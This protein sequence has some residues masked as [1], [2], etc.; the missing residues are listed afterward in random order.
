[1]LL[2]T[3]LLLASGAYADTISIGF[4]EPG[5]HGGAIHTVGT[6]SGNL[7][8][9]GLT[10]G[11]FTVNDV[12]AQDFAVLGAPGLLNTQTHDISS[13]RPGIL[14]IYI[15]AQGLSFTGA[16]YF[17]SSFAVKALSGSI[18]AVEE[19]TYFSPTNG[20]YNVGQTLLN[21]AAFIDIGTQGPFV[22]AGSTS[23]TY[24][25][26]EKYL[27][28]DIGGGIGNDNLTV[29]LSASPVPEPDS[30]ILMG[31]GLALAGLLYYRRRN[32]RPDL[33]ASIA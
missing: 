32:K 13:T 24:S 23:G 33:L 26:T 3:P 10:Y 29:D 4:Q 12:S 8:V 7:T 1:M 15:T 9:S 14:T 21:S 2:A 16:Q 31:S 30:L 17:A 27:I 25:V 6:G 5:V 22:T 28:F 11:T 20:L 19:S 18:V